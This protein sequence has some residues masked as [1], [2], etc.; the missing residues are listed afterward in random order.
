MRNAIRRRVGAPAG[1]GRYVLGSALILAILV[2]PFAVASGEGDPI[3]GGTRNPSNNKSA[4]LTRETGILTENGTYGTRQS[5][6]KK[7][8]GGGAIYGCRSAPGHEPCVRA[9]NLE[10]GRAFEFATSNG[11][12]GGFI[13]VG[14]GPV[15]TKAVPFNTNAAARVAN[16]NA[17]RV[18]DL[19][20]SEIVAQAKDLWA[21][22]TADGGLPRKNAAVTSAAKLATG[23]Y[24]VVFDRD[25]TACAYNV[26]IG[27]S[28]T[29]EPALGE[30]A[31]SQR[32]GNVKAVA[33]V[34]ADSAGTKA[35]R[36]FHLTVN[37]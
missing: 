25:V 23:E 30:T 18:D 14:S 31:A 2:A 24:E 27:S 21:V 12:E 19:H 4:A 28:D 10:N 9:N 13:D 11:T 5:N 20:A 8:D 1:P 17:D 16:L 36:P 3:E 34:T 32:A 7:G 37:C 35:D 26:S 22:V 6:K 29:T 33:V 15:N